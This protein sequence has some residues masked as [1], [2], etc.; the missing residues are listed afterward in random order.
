[1]N[2]KSICAFCSRMKRGR[3]YACARRENYNVLAMGHHL[4]DLAESLLMNLFHNGFLR[5][6]KASYLVKERDL[7]VIRPFAFIRERELREFALSRKFPIIPENCPAC[8]KA[9]KERARMKQLLA[10]QEHLFP[11]I[12]NEI[13]SAIEPIIGIG[14]VGLESKTSNI[15]KNNNM[16]D[17]KGEKMNE[18]DLNE[19]DLPDFLK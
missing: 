3:L 12:Y 2:C 6:M 17:K 1:M 10:T 7:R 11:N 4:D 9:P 8:F 15:F 16:E 19:Q 14:E 13:R 5:S 18:D